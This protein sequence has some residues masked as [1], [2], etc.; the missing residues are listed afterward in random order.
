MS[1]SIGTVNKARFVGII[2]CYVKMW[3]SAVLLLG[4]V[5][6]MPTVRIQRDLMVVPVWQDLQQMGKRV[7]VRTK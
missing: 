3:T 1:M 7:Q 4:P 5:T 2:H 6:P